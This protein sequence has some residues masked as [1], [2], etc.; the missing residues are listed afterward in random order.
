MI[1]ILALIGGFCFAYCGVLP[2]IATAKAGKSVGTPVAIAW[3]IV[4]GAVAMYF[5]LLAEYGFNFLLT[6][7]YFV[8]AASWAVIV[9]YHYFPRR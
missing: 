5:Y 3:M 7:N 2:A 1:N 9:F 6:I 4:V 8:E